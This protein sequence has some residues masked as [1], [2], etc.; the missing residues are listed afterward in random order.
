MRDSMALSLAT[1]MVSPSGSKLACATQLATCGQTPH[2]IPVLAVTPSPRWKC[3]CCSCF[4]RGSPLVSAHCK[5]VVE[6]H[7]TRASQHWNP[8]RQV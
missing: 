3:S 2:I 1:A 5:N 6:G 4:A 8:Q 7:A